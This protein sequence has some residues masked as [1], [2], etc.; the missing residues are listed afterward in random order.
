MRFHLLESKSLFPQESL[1][2]FNK[3][4]ASS[5][6]IESSKQATQK[7]ITPNYTN[8]QLKRILKE[9]HGLPIL[10][11][12]FVSHGSDGSTD[13]ALDNLLLTQSP[14]QINIYDNQHLGTHLDIISQFVLPDPSKDV[15]FFEDSID[16]IQR[17]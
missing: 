12:S 16:C 1:H 4:L 2:K 17:C 5:A 15:N 9:N 7:Q 10:N 6:A 14:C 8:L 13:F 3:M 11:C